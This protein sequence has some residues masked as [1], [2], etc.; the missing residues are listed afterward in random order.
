MMRRTPLVARVVVSSFLREPS[1][2][3]SFKETLAECDANGIDMASS[4]T[5]DFALLQSKLFKY[6]VVRLGDELQYVCRHP[7][8]SLP[9]LPALVVHIILLTTVFFLFRNLGRFS[10]T[11][12][13][14]PPVAL[15]GEGDS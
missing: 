2:R 3:K 10:S 8:G 6:R 13:V 5:S 14:K 12:L 4:L 7:L 11:A 1:E 9:S 15:P